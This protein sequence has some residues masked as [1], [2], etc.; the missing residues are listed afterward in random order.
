[1]EK[2]SQP[3]G[4]PVGYNGLFSTL[5]LMMTPVAIAWNATS[6]MGGAGKGQRRDEW[7]EGV[8]E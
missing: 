8:V 5:L 4:H 2:G 3:W 1:M 6:Q 7:G